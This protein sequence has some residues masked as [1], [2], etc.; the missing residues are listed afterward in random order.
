MSFQT[1]T[2]KQK[3][4]QINLDLNIYG[5]IAEIG[6]GQEVARSFFHAGGAAGT[7]AKSISAYDMAVSD[8][9]YGREESGRYVCEPRLIKM[10]KREFDQLI[11]RLSDKRPK[12][13]TFFAF[14]DTVA[15][16]SFRGKT[17]GH[18]WMGVKFQ[19]AAKGQ[20][21]QIIIHVKMLDRENLQQ[22]QALGIIGVNLIHGCYYH[23]DDP[24]ALIDCLMESLTPDRVEIDMIR[25]EGP[26]FR[27]I[28]SR[29]LCLELVK[30]N[31]TNAILF[32]SYGN[33]QQAS[34][35]IYKKNVLLLRGSW[36][37]PTLV[38]M[39][40][41]ES[42]TKLFKEKLGPGEQE[43]LMVLPEIS[44]SKLREKGEIDNKDFLARV[45]L[46]SSLGEKVLISNF[47]TYH[48]LASFIRSYTNK[49]MAVVLGVYNLEEIL[50]KSKYT[51]K[52]SGLLGA[53]G[54]LVGHNT[55]LLL[56][57]ATEVDQGKGSLSCIINSQNLNIKE[58]TRV[59]VNYLK[60]EGF[61]DDITDF[62]A[63]ITGIWSR[64]ILKMIE[65][66]EEGW[67]KMV[68]QLVADIVKDKKL[69]GHSGK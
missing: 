27:G 9:I 18:G 56:Y 49:R 20:P 50:D 54:A 38:N 62:N 8:A 48:E 46:L 66:D 29:L 52:N 51:E 63:D 17:E 19:S 65:A 6:A 59:L 14:A 31:Y 60:K 12:E 2:P 68:P 53:V 47:G 37:P 41:L 26:V 43:H 23:A 7:I 3:A 69:F 58:N 21:N 24:A 15:A 55:Q 67:E 30:K 16:K 10:L 61:L 44:M 57:P 36:R 39:N 11:D 28:D 40:M 33:V 34:D 5:T 35:Q 32:D 42:G 13:T 25:V 45:D 22:Q 4:L 1:L 64:K